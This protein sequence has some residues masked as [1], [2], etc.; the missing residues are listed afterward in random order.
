M[1][2]N[3][4]FVMCVVVLKKLCRQVCT[5]GPAERKPLP[6]LPLQHIMVLRV[7]SPTSIQR[8]NIEGKA[9]KRINYPSCKELKGILCGFRGVDHHVRNSSV[10]ARTGN[11]ELGVGKARDMTYTVAT[12]PSDWKQERC[13]QHSLMSWLNKKRKP[14]WSANQISSEQP[15]PEKSPTLQTFSDITVN[16]INLYN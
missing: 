12:L 14:C 15:G 4:K 3:P 16:L 11:K 9:E 1:T 2:A 8:P 10:R 5:Q 13:P 7:P 6:Q